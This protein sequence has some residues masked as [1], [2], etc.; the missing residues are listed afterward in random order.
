M[1]FPIRRSAFL[2]V[3]L[4]LFVS[5]LAAPAQVRNSFQARSHQSSA[6]S[7]VYRLFVPKSYTA[8]RKYPL[9]VALH[10]VGE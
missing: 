6:V 3:L 2:P 8:V 10:G 5:A 1:G 9:L 4:V 7:M